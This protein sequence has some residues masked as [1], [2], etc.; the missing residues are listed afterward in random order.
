[1]W[2][3]PYTQPSTTCHLTA[4]SSQKI[5]IRRAF[6]KPNLPL[7]SL[8]WPLGVKAYGSQKAFWNF[9][10]SLI[11]HI[12]CFLLLWHPAHGTLCFWVKSATPLESHHAVAIISLRALFTQYPAFC[13]KKCWPGCLTSNEEHF[14]ISQGL[15][16]LICI[17]LCSTPM[18]VGRKYLF[19]SHGFCS[20]TW[21]LSAATSGNSTTFCQH[22]TISVENQ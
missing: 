6:S 15:G 7:G 22:V 16:N 14:I 11:S 20:M 12:F 9:Q 2:I 10:P 4:L 8:S 3:A 18:A 21:Q 1:M 13:W 17:Y 5:E 19:S